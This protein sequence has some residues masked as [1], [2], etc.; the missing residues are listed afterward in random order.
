MLD[1]AG[2][3]ST[4]PARVSLAVCCCYPVV[5]KYS[6]GNV[7]TEYNFASDSTIDGTAQYQQ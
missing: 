7:T 4:I 5:P 1:R 6:I 2:Y 3:I